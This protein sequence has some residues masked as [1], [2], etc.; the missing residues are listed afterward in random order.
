MKKKLKVIV[1]CLKP[2]FPFLI[3]L[4]Q[5]GHV[6]RRH[7]LSSIILSHEVVHSLKSTKTSGMLIKIDLSKAFNKLSWQYISDVLLPFGFQPD[8][9]KWIIALISFDFFTLL[10]NGAPYD[11]FRP[12]RGIRQGDPLSP[13]LFILM[14]EGLGRCIKVIIHSQKL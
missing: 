14:A 4:E 2:L 12:S 13:F 7:I 3:S 5:S 9:V 11:P 10:I 6:E 8:W 1:I